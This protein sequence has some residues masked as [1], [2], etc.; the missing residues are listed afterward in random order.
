MAVANLASTVVQAE[1]ENQIGQVLQ[2]NSDGTGTKASLSIIEQRVNTQLQ[3]NLLQ[4][5]SEGPRASSAVWSAS[6]TDIL[7]VPGATLNGT[8]ALNL[9]GTIEKIATSVNV[10]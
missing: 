8:L 1:T 9:N 4:Q 5:F 2:L 3:I 7:N 10:T 6:K